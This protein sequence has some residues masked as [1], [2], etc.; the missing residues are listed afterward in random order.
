MMRK[1]GAM[2]H[3]DPTKPRAQRK[4]IQISQIDGCRM[5]N[6]FGSSI[7]PSNKESPAMNAG[8]VENGNDCEA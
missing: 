6:P 4:Q 1:T 3:S 8:L 5:R 2:V 7:D